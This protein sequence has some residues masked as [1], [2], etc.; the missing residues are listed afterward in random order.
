MDKTIIIT[1]YESDLIN[2]TAETFLANGW[3]VVATMKNP[4]FADVTYENDR[5]IIIQLADNHMHSLVRV[6]KI[7][8]I[9]FKT[10]DLIVNCANQDFFDV[11]NLRKLNLDCSIVNLYKDQNIEVDVS[12]NYHI[13]VERTVG[14]LV[15]PDIAPAQRII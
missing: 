1:V 12:G 6:V 9:E 4:T 2:Y 7:A 14:R 3:N 11:N 13:S 10:I 8:T 5:L 15:K